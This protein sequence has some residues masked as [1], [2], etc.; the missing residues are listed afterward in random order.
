MSE[1][2]HVI[3]DPNRQWLKP[4]WHWIISIWS[5]IQSW[6]TKCQQGTRL[7]WSLCSVIFLLKFI[8]F[9]WQYSCHSSS[10]HAAHSQIQGRK[11]SSIKH[12]SFI[13]KQEAFQW[14]Y[15][16][17]VSL[18]RTVSWLQGKLGKWESEKSTR[19][20]RVGLCPI[21]IH[22]LGLERSGSVMRRGDGFKV[23]TNS[24][25]HVCNFLCRCQCTGSSLQAWPVPVW[26][27]LR[28]WWRVAHLLHGHTLLCSYQCPPWG[29]F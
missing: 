24:V 23:G 20:Y 2:I 3:K 7:F 12:L 8:A 13:R 16:Y 9:R 18:A 26:G 17:N 25:H 15:L 19:G 28:F 27:D 14:I 1:R 6:W 22:Q 21:P 11:D 5:L 4:W 29:L 10:H